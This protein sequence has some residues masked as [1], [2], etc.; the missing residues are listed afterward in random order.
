MRAP[1]LV[2]VGGAV[3]ASARWV[4]G[5]LFAREPGGFPWATLLVNLAGCAAIGWCARRIRHPELWLLVVTGGLGGFTTFS[6]FAVETRE[7][8]TGGHAARAA[9]YVAISVAG[10][11]GAARLTAGRNM[12]ALAGVDE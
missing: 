5:E 2:A 6:T 10:G 11:L 9:A 4:T 3:G 8:V 1:L 7:L 12:P